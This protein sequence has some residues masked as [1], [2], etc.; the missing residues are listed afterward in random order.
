MK[1]PK[2]TMLVTSLVI[3]LPIVAG[4]LLWNQL[5]DPMPTH[6]NMHNE[7]DGWSSKP[8]AVFGIPLIL[9]ALQ[10]VCLVAYRTDPK[11]R[12]I[13]P[14]V[15]GLVL[16]IIPVMSLLVGAL[17]YLVALGR[18]INVGFFVCLLLGILFVLIG[19]YLPK[20]RQTYTVGIRIPWT[21]HDEGNWAYTHRLGGWVWTAGGLLVILCAFLGWMPAILL[22]LALMVLLPCAASFLYDRRHRREKEE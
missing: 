22:I 7:P 2:L 8:F 11:K 6:F 1:V 10:W 4:I 12:N 16:W 3:L 5:P 13:H 18:E 20:C 17:C 9:L 15:M 19:N 21:L 14:T